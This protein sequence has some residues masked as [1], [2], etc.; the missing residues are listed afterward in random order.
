MLVNVSRREFL[1]LAALTGAGAA[2]AACAP[3]AAPQQP[4]A[5]EP[6]VEQPA[7]QPAAPAGE[8]IEIKLLNENWGEIYNNLMTV[9]GDEYMKENP[10]I[11]LSWEFDPEWRTKLTTLLAAGTPPDLAFMRPDYLAGVA[12]KGVLLALDEY[13]AGAGK[14]PT[15]FVQA[16]Y[17]SG[18]FQNKLFAVPGGTDVWSLYYNKGL[19]EAAGLDPE[20]PPKS[21]SE[22]EEQSAKLLKVADDG[23]IEQIP[24]TY[25]SWFT[26]MWMHAYGGVLYDEANGK[27]TANDATNVKCW[28]WL[29]DYYLSFGDIDQLTAFAQRPGFFD[30]GNPFATNQCAYVMDGFWYYEAIDQH[31]P[32]MKY[33]VGYWPTLG[34]TDAEKANWQIGGWHYSIPK[35]VPN[36]DAGWDVLRYMFVDNSGKM[37]CDTLNGP[38]VIA[39]FQP[40]ISCLQGKMGADNRMAPYLHVFTEQAEAATRQFPIIE[41]Q[42]FYT[43]ELTRMFDLV[44]RK[45]MTSQAALDEVTK[46]VQED[47]DKIRADGG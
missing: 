18:S 46:N 2:V 42:T 22:L 40:W 7:E 23:T 47:L 16:Q 15:D 30:A 13:I 36:P 27:I 21:I 29:S 19:Y 45:Q 1:R 4:A 3:A 31:A 39:E 35:G 11:K 24:M 26:P 9:I 5:A 28:E 10:N 32:D 33:G 37:G 41:N 6:A 25:L 14:K 8:Q 38:G 34:G 17:K 44:L 43:D 12:P 20:A